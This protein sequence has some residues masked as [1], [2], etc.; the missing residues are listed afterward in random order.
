MKSEQRFVFDTNTLIS[1]ACFDRSFGR[2]AY[3]YVRDHSTFL[4]CRESVAELRDV[5]DRGKFNKFIEPAA[6]LEFV[7]AYID[8]AE[9]IDIP[10]TFRVSRDPTDDKFPELAVVG[11]AQFIVTRDK[12]LL[13]FDPFQGV[14]ILDAENLVALLA[15]QITEG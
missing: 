2:R 9:L 1:A 10:G 15:A 14:Q 6:R 3:E 5:A 4:V 11:K 12:D 13:V 7:E 8:R